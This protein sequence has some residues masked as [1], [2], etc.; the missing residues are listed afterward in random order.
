MRAFAPL[1]T[2]TVAAALLL[3]GCAAEPAAPQ[4]TSSA[5]SES[6]AAGESP[7]AT[8]SAPTA[9]GFSAASMSSA[10][11]CSALDDAAVLP[12]LVASD[13]RGTYPFD[14]EV[15]CKAGLQ[16]GAVIITVLPGSQGGSDGVAERF[17]DC[18]S[19]A[20]SDTSVNGYAVAT[21]ACDDPRGVNV[22]SEL[23]GDN[24]RALLTISSHPGSTISQHDVLARIGDVWTE[25]LGS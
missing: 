12:D 22:Y 21:A 11:L 6:P 18:S 19:P 17:N 24:F 1:A 25:L 20:M 15:G 9:V 23:T 2:L 14:G 7:T 8:P 3:T 10:D 13:L 4:P 5:P 16:R